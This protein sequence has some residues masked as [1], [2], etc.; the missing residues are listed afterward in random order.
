MVCVKILNKHVVGTLVNYSYYVL[1]RRQEKERGGK[2]E[3][4]G[5]I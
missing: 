2:A 1:I 4:L 3:S 5:A